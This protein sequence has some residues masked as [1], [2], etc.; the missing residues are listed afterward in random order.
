MKHKKS[1]KQNVNSRRKSL[2]KKKNYHQ[3]KIKSSFVL[4]VKTH[5]GHPTFQCE[6]INKLTKGLR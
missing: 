3:P 1:S 5:V 2:F 6:E 4:N